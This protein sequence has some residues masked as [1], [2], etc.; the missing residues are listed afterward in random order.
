MPLAGSLI[1]MIGGFPYT[2][3]ATWMVFGAPTLWIGLLIPTILRLLG[4]IRAIGTV[5][6]KVSILFATTGSGR[7][8]G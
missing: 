4:S 7:I 3:S 2:F 8:I 5:V 6:V 1:A